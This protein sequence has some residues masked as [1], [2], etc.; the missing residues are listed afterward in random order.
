MKHEMQN[1][2]AQKGLSLIFE[3]RISERFWLGDPVRI[4]QV[5]SNITSNA[6]KF[7]QTGN[8][9]FIAEHRS[10]SG[11]LR[12][13]IKDTGIG[14]SNDQVKRL[15]NR[16]EQADITTTRKYG[17][18]GLGM[19]ITKSLVGLMLGDISVQ[20]AQ[21]SGS[22]FTVTLPA[23]QSNN[24][25]AKVTVPSSIRDLSD[26]H[27]L[28]VEDNAMNQMIANAMLA[29]T[30]VQ[31]TLAENGQIALDRLNDGIDLVLM[32]IQM[33]VMDGIEATGHIKNMRPDLAIIALTANVSSADIA[34]YHST[35]FADV[36]AK[37]VD[38][39]QMLSIIY[40]HI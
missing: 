20:S 11:Q 37:P 21:G 15:F 40:K 23:V 12:F 25:P 13:I 10:D 28:L 5:L 34:L 7:T 19:S 9:T 30:N 33:P 16:F 32:D 39:K 6:F 18:T 4:Y 36:I 26:F 24:K 31:I 38:K 2:A 17:G 22:S 27:I 8:I 14:M 3:N 29:E 35:G 1:Q